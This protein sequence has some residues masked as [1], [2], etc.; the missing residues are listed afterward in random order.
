MDDNI[1]KPAD[2]H[3]RQNEKLLRMADEIRFSRESLL[4]NENLKN[5]LYYPAA[6][7][8]FE[9]VEQFSKETDIFIYADVNLGYFTNLFS[10]RAKSKLNIIKSTL[11]T[12]EHIVQVK[13]LPKTKR[14][15]RLI[16]NKFKKYKFSDGRFRTEPARTPVG[17]F[18]IETSKNSSKSLFYIVNEGY[19]TYLHLFQMGNIAPNILFMHTGAMGA[20]FGVGIPAFEC[21]KKGVEVLFKVKPGKI[22]KR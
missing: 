22:V 18:Q 20:S 2:I 8:D 7:C 9:P 12:L 14:I 4:T 16:R 5:A 17:I 13:S 6:G 11:T 3:E 21:K 19:W 15:D 10:G 1:F